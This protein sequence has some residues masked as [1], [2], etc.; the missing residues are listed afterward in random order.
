ML[1]AEVGLNVRYIDLSVDLKGTCATAPCTGL[2][3]TESESATIYVPMVY[4][5]VQLSPTDSVALEA[6]Y[7]GLA[8]NGD[9][10]TDFIGRL[11]VK[12]F[13]PVFIAAGYRQEQIE[14][15]ESD[16]EIDMEFKGPF[17]EAGVGFEF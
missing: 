16:V 11:K 8:F 1:N 12:P 4:A 10:Y 7:R 13:G 15:D 17:L 9:N 6:E 2:S 3:R 5:G 14:V